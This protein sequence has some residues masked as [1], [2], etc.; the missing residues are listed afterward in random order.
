MTT[1]LTVTP[2]IEM[3]HNF[4][5]GWKIGKH[6]AKSGVG[7]GIQPQVTAWTQILI[8]GRTNTEPSLP[9]TACQRTFQ[10]EGRGRRLD[11]GR[12]EGGGRGEGEGGGGGGA[13]GRL[14]YLL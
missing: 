8:G 9:L 14:V 2:G 7:V 4:D 6:A 10:P 1:H 5:L 3:K 11:W 13:G 12:S